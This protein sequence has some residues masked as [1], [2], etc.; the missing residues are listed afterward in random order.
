MAT[1]H[2]YTQK[3][4]DPI[5]N[6]ISGEFFS[7]EAVGNVT[8]ALIREGIQNTLDA[9]CKNDSGV[10]QPAHAR[11]FLSGLDGAL[12]PSRAHYWF[13]ALWPHVMAPGNGLR[14]QPSLDTPCPFLVFEDFGTIGLTG[15]P[16]EHRVTDRVTNH[17]L[18]FFR[19][20]G[21]S[22]KGE[23][24]RGSW[25][26]GKT[27]FARASR[28]SSFL[29][30]TVRS[31][32]KRHMIL[33]RS[34]LKYHRV[35]DESYKSDGYF[36]LARED[37]FML[38]T[39]DL[40]T[41]AAFRSDFGVKR[42]AESG[43]SI[44]VPWYEG[45]GSMAKV[46][47]GV[48]QGFFYPILT[49]DLAV[50]IA[51]PAEEMMLDQNSI[52]PKVEAVGGSLAIELLRLIKFAE[53]AQTRIP[54]EF[55]SLAPP[56]PDRAQKW[57]PE[58]VPTD[59]LKYVR[60]SLAQR[61]RVALRVPMFVQPRNT[62]PQPTFFNIFLEYS[63]NDSGKPVFI[64]DELIISDVK[65]PHIPQVRSLVIVEDGPLAS[66]LR[67]AETP[68]HTQWNQDTST[69]K[70]K[71][72]FGPGAIG[73]VRLGVSELI[74]II[75][76]SEQQP[77]PTITIDFFSVPAPDEDE[78]VP[79]RR[80]RPKPVDGSG[81]TPPVPPI[82][83]SQPRRFR[84]EKLRGGFAIRAGDAGASQPPFIDI[85]VAYDVRRGNPLRKYHAADFDLGR[86]PIRYDMEL[87]GIDVKRAIGNRM[88]VA[89]ECPD[90][91]LNVTGFDPDR[92]LYVR[93]MVKEAADVD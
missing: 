43:L 62:E 18:N 77:D 37:G 17:F 47:A 78:A 16:D 48:L 76:Q 7:T 12:S 23:Q 92:D 87:K 27:V 42:Q 40:P 57:A 65:S 14:D 52:I 68:A 67:D 28:I 39:E 49:G 90:F 50:T 3:P 34:V 70:N 64:R 60:Q 33:G 79:S 2:F 8:E 4:T 61:H 35:G 51:T 73:F 91:N 29:G 53:W 19:A 5:H 21:H 72:K 55:Q 20:E 15:D 93:A 74:R 71:Y 38:P 26:V 11:L 25:G 84:I 88:L 46:T 83:P 6:P 63:G 44:V 10:R 66:L 85:R 13:D 59:V 24:D 86:S 56:P 36:G 75:N 32:D 1:W 45:E 58:L 22:D 89:V 69:F 81:P 9:R 30:L 82:P 31:D 41:L 80:R 54:A